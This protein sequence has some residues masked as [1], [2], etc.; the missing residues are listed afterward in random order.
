MWGIIPAAGKGSRI[1]PLA[2]S[3]ELL[4]VGG[5]GDGGKWRPRAVSDYLIERLVIGGATRICFVIS[6][7][8]SDI[9]EYYGGSAYGTPI[10]Y[11]VQPEPL[12]L[13]DAIFRAL[14]VIGERE[15]V[16]IGLPDT[17]WFPPDG[18]RALPD[19]R[20]SFLLFP[21]DR[22]QFFDAVISAGDGHVQEI[23]V[24]QPA[25]ASKWIWGA[26]KM[27]GSVLKSLH[28]LW[29]RRR[30]EYIGT[31]I[32][33]WLAE[34]GEAWGVRAGTSYMDVGAME[35]YFEAM[36]TLAEPQPETAEPGSFL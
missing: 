7:A 8:K 12:G 31:L 28:E 18:M 34:G 19:D 25:P 10:C 22:P 1:Q 5:H 9:L 3:K 15:P 16:M 35:G 29:L 11:C 36:R 2:F 27:P 24:K 30:D 33:A 26:F 14:P 13:C 20:L 6:P 23:Q 4:P 32:N 21:V 17:I